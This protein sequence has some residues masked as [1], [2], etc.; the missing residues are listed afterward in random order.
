MVKTNPWGKP[1]GKKVN[2]E[3][4]DKALLDQPAPADKAEV[5]RRLFDA[6]RGHRNYK[7]AGAS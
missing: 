2:P 7:P 3:E 5:G 6:L 1:K 4:Q